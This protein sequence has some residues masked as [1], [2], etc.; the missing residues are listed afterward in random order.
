MPVCNAVRVE[1]G[2]ADRIRRIL[3]FNQRESV[4]SHYVV[5]F[6]IQ[7]RPKN[8]PVVYTQTINCN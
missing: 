4:N 8:P 5:D 1:Q 7:R 3:H 6:V 2:W